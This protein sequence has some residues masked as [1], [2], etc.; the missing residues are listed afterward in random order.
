MPINFPSNPSINQQSTQNNRIYQ[1][2]GSAWEIVGS[3]ISL[4]A[5]QI[6]D[7]NTSVSGL[8]STSVSF[9]T[10]THN[11]PP[12]S[13]FATLDTRNSIAVLEFDSATDESA[14]FMGV[15]SSNTVVTSG[16]VVNLWWMADT[17]TSGNVL[18]SV[19][20]ESQGTDNNSNSFDIATSGIATA[21]GTSGIET[22]TAI[23][24]TAID[25]LT[26]GKRYRLKVN[27]AATNASDTMTGDAQLIAVAVRAV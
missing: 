4:S 17:A 7:F 13:G 12:A 9:F 2:T 19:Q 22:E 14:V 8:L 23:T 1:W 27:R 6:S 3:G 15:L 11:Q 16:L 24:C 21:N 5:S 25:S 26:A 10:A 20:F 18:W